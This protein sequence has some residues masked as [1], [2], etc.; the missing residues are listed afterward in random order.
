VEG[1]CDNCGNPVIQREDDKEA[2]IQTRLNAYME[3]TRPLKDY[4][5]KKGHL[6][7]VNGLGTADEVYSRVEKAMVGH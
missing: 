2:V 3:S 4:Y 5:E 6:K 7:E 1:V